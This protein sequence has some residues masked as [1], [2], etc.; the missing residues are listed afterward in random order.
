[1][2]QILCKK[3]EFLTPDETDGSCEYEISEKVRNEHL[4]DS[5]HPKTSVPFVTKTIEIDGKEVQTVAPEFESTFDVQLPKELWKSENYSRFCNQKLKE[6]IQNDAELRKKFTS[7]Q[8]KDIENGKNPRGYDWHHD[9]EPGKMQ[10]VDK[11]IH[12]ST[13]HTGGKSLWGS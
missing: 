8:L 6:A 9:A 5:V 4:A 10:L 1:M 11:K 3:N 2:C 13:A 7:E 12:R